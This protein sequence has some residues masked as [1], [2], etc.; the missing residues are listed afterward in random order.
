M[1]NKYYPLGNIE[2]NGIVRIIRIVFGVV[3]IAIAAFWLV[4]NIRSLKADA[5]LWITIIFLWAFGLYQIWAGFGK[6]NRFIEFGS[7]YIRLRKNAFFAPRVMNVAEIEKIE[8]FPMNLVF[9]LKTGK[10]IMLRFGATYQ[11]LNEKIK[12]DLLI[13]VELNKIPFEIVEEKI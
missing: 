6:A 4:F 1:E 7:N 10:R 12:D 5:T 2:K 11:D 9:F 13:F 8:L 3:C